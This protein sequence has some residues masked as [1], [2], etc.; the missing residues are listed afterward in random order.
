MLSATHRYIV[1]SLNYKYSVKKRE[2]LDLSHFSSI[3][4]RQAEKIHDENLSIVMLRQRFE[5]G[6]SAI[7]LTG[8]L[9][10]PYHDEEGNK[11]QRPNS[12]SC[13]PIK[14]KKFRR[15][16]VQPNLRGSNDPRVG[17]K[18]ATFQLFFSVGLG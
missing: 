2:G 11:L 14:K 13:K 6:T 17:R 12:K 7:G 1:C 18:M 4:L 3:F 10:S 16:S 15:F 5:P 8:V 9:I